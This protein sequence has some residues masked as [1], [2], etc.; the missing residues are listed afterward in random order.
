MPIMVGGYVS[1]Q[2]RPANDSSGYFTTI[3]PFIP[4]S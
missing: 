3:V 1:A 2:I 4:A